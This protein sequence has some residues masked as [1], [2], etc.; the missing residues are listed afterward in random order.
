M[1][2]LVMNFQLLATYTKFFMNYTYKIICK[3]LKIS[4]ITLILTFD[5]N[6]KKKI[7]LVENWF[8]VKIPVFLSFFENVYF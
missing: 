3:L 2:N 8:C 5:Y 7:D 4:V 6:H 1:E